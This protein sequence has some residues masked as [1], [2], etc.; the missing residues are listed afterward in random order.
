[1]A[2]RPRVILFDVVE[3]LFSLDPF[4]AQLAELGMDGELWAARLFRNVFAFEVAG[5]WHPF[6]E[7]AAA[8]LA[9]MMAEKGVVVLERERLLASL[10]EL[11]PFDDVRPALAAARAAG[12]GCACLT[13][14]SAE[15]TKRLFRRAGI[16][17]IR[18]V[19][20]DELQ[21]CKPLWDVYLHAADALG[22]DPHDLAMVSAHDW[23]IE[24][25]RQASFT[26]AW[27]SRRG[28]AFSPLLPAPDIGA[29]SL[30][31][32]VERLLALDLAPSETL[33]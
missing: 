16:D 21:H 24:G 25:A 20:A 8:E 9:V 3:T 23:D 13:N 6:H 30:V 31:E 5:L 26:T 4:V 17:P 15:S 14:D 28:A 1:V 11:P 18:V 19:S 32:A 7:L 33:H 2:Q 22:H 29:G 12:V 10:S 27:V